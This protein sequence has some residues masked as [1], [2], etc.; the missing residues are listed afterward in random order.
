ML[1]ISLKGKKAFVA[2]IGDDQGYGW[3]I[4]KAL[5]EAEAEI[6]VGT[7]APIYKIFYQLMEARKV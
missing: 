5:A 2:G 4:A 1:E 6:I 3:A 7:W